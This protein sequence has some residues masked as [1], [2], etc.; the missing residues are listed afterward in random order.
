MIKDIDRAFD[1]ALLARAAYSNGNTAS[2]NLEG[3]GWRAIGA[4]EL[5]MPGRDFSRGYFEERVPLVGNGL[6]ASALVARKGE[7]LVLAF[8]GSD[9]P[10]DLA[11]AGLFGGALQREYF[12]LYKHLIDAVLS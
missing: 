1:L 4:D 10:L 5:G 6:K 11:A 7:Q 9:E 8:R 12:R 2:V 3:S